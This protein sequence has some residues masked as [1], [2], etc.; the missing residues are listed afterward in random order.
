[1]SE[2]DEKTV[3]SGAAITDAQVPDIT[4]C[5]TEV[6][7]VC[8]MT[9]RG[10]P[11]DPNC[12]WGAPACFWGLSGIAKSDRMEQAASACSLPFEVLLPSQKQ[13]EDFSGV[14]VPNFAALARAFSKTLTSAFTRILN[15]NAA[16]GEEEFSLADNVTIECMLPQIRR[17]CREGRGVLF[18]DEVSCAA[19][20]TQGS[21]LGMVNDGRVGDVIL[22]PGIRTL[23]AA[24]PPKYSAG[25]WSLEPPMANRM[26]HF[27]LRCPSTQEWIDWL[28]NEGERKELDVIRSEET[29]RSRW[30]DKRSFVSGLLA[31]YMRDRQT[32]LHTQPLPTHSQSGYCWP[33]PRTWALAGRMMSTV[34]ALDMPDTLILPVVEGCIGEG[35]AAEFLTWVRKAD[36]PSPEEVLT[37][38]WTPNTKRLDIT[39]AVTSAVASYVRGMQDKSAQAEAGVA[40]WGFLKSVIDAKL[41]D[42]AMPAAE[43]LSRARLGF[44]SSNPKLK[45]ASAPVLEE[46]AQ[47]KQIDYHVS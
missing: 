38:G 45:A 19:P 33:S 1:M 46:L 3:E 24:N 5:F 31:G 42:I 29:L 28:L 7:Q 25:G 40:A 41:S 9:P 26:A 43:V 23:L 44:K 17:L 10:N 20:A 37:K 34:Y 21:M 30:N 39:M 47:Q 4:T 16:A 14:P 32:A 18:V 6:V 12:K 2:E 8:I 35:A 15:K 22:S 27:Q 11:Y 13:P 36:L